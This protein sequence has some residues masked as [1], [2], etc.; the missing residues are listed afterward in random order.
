MAFLN[1]WTKRRSHGVP[2]F[3]TPIGHRP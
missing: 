2:G 3:L 1:T